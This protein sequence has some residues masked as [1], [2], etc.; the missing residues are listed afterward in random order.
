MVRPI[1]DLIPRDARINRVIVCEDMNFIWDDPELKQ[2]AKMWKQRYSIEGIS[3]YF[4]RDPDE[5]L[6][7]L[8]HLARNDKIKRRKGGLFA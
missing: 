5:V 1:T 7:A 6:F 2:I 3:K 4:D 8:I